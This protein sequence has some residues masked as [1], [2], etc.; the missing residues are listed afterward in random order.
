M[1]AAG[2]RPDT[3]SR[4]SSCTRPGADQVRHN[5]G[6][7]TDLIRSQFFFQRP[8]RVGDTLMLPQMFEPTL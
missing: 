8:V 2:A 4:I 6:I 3:A 7:V 5:R 1:G